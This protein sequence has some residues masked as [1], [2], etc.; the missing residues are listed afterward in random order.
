MGKVVTVIGR[1]CAVYFVGKGCAVVMG[2]GKR[3]K[4]VDESQG[5]YIYRLAPQP[6]VLGVAN[7]ATHSSFTNN[8]SRP[9]SHTTPSLFPRLT[10]LAQLGAV[11]HNLL[12]NSQ[13]LIP[14]LKLFFDSG[15]Y[16]ENDLQGLFSVAE[17]I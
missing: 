2:E 4:E 9:F 3:W 14:R 13:Q 17:P 12:H 5:K 1:H 15:R 10:R 11:V 16:F 8:L 7:S 6:V